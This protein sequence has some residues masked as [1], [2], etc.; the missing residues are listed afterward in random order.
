MSTSPSVDF[1]RFDPQLFRAPGS[2]KVLYFLSPMIGPQPWIAHFAQQFRVNIAVIYVPDWDNDLTPWPAPGEPPGDPD[3]QGLA[4]QF[5]SD[6]LSTAIPSV[7]RSL[8]ID[9]GAARRTLCGISLSGLFAVWA[10]ANTSFFHNIIS[11]SG[12]FWYPRFPQWLESAT[13]PDPEQGR[14][15]ISLGAKESLSP[16]KAFRSVA[17][18]TE[19]VIATLRSKGCSVTWRSEPGTHYANPQP[20]LLHALQ[21][22]Y[23]P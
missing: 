22:I 12:S 7:D 15:Y 10:R 6:M 1:F 9:P 18:D 23:T 5:L 21:S 20:R 4:P 13:I 3:F 19:S 8:G 16:V 11:I 17:A 2:S 14:I